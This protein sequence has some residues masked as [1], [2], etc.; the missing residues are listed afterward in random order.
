[1]LEMK[2][3]TKK[4]PGVVALDQVDFF[5]KPG[6]VHVLLG[7]NGAGKSTL[8]KI[9]C[10]VL[11]KDQGEIF[12]LGKKILEKA[13]PNES[14]R[15]G[16]AMIFQE[17]SLF[18]QLTI[19]E[20]ICMPRTRGL[21]VNWRKM[22]QESRKLL[23]QFGLDASV[24]KKVSELTVGEQQIIEIAKALKCNAKLVVMDEPTS[25]LSDSEVKSLFSYIKRMTSQGI[26]VV[27]I[28]HRLE[29]VL[30]IGDRITVLRDGKLVGT[31]E[32]VQGKPRDATADRLVE[33]MVGRKLE[34]VFPKCDAVKRD[35]FL[36]VEGLSKSGM[37][38]DISFEVRRGEIL[39]VAGLMGSGRSE[40]MRA[41]FGAIRKDR[42]T[43]R[44]SGKPVRI[45]SPSDAIRMGIAYLTE[46]RKSEGIVLGL[47][48]MEN[49]SL[50]SLRS[51]SS[52]GVLSPVKEKALAEKFIQLLN[53]RPPKMF[54]L[55]RNLSGGN[56]QKVVVAKW[57]SANCDLLILD[58]PTRGIDVGAKR[59]IYE[60]IN[61]LAS[62]GKAIIMISSELPEIV[63]LSDRVVVMREGRLVA[64]LSGSDINEQTIIRYATA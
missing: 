2:R 60:L 34:S 41:I 64:E 5:V 11:P 4:F 3:I 56:Q 1:M 12:F 19:A 18:P 32:N 62:Q 37:F 55:A 20:N 21:S 61:L 33:M 39:G 44:V 14:S 28:G 35:V 46:D 15:A 40:V 43:I 45:N 30:E 22:R 36:R 17:F 48:V 16:I 10:G 6:E 23:E 7:E 29:E 8:M 59:E 9:L 47:N 63:G 50:A 31:I 49:I 58:E 13:N 57:L 54:R 52:Q 25:A 51:V 26:G 53:I 27:F 38:E 24:D 42:G